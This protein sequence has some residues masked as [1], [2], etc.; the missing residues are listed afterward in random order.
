MEARVLTGALAR[1][2]IRLDDPAYRGLLGITHGGGHPPGQPLSRQQ[3]LRRLG[4][5]IA[6][7][8]GNIMGITLACLFDYILYLADGPWILGRSFYLVA[9]CAL[10]VT[11]KIYRT[12]TTIRQL[13]TAGDTKC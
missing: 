8:P 6:I 3:R 9:F 1:D 11:S 7:F 13:Q 12:R 2:R 5:E 4:S 10:G